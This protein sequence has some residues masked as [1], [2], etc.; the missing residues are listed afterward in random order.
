[1]DARLPRDDNNSKRIGVLL[2][3]IK[4]VFFPG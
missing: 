3:G 4:A 1:M 2:F